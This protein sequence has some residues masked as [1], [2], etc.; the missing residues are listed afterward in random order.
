MLNEICRLILI[1]DILP[2]DLEKNHLIIRP[3]E[4]IVKKSKIFALLQSNKS[5]AP[6]CN[7]NIA[8]K[9][10]LVKNLLETL[11]NGGKYESFVDELEN[12][13]SKLSKKLKDG[14]AELCEKLGVDL[15]SFT[16]KNSNKKLQFIH[17]AQSNKKY[18]IVS[19]K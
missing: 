5:T 16:C 18:L 3:D 6:F 19:I 9:V 12:K 13:C 8:Q 17:E 4:S 1:A 2:Y 15:L 7:L 14:E 11:L 10:E